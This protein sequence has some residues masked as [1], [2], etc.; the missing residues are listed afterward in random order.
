M[1]KILVAVKALDIEQRR[2]IRELLCSHFDCNAGC[3]RNGYSDQ[4]IGREANVSWPIVR[5]MRE[6][7]LGPI[8]QLPVETPHAATTDR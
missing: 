6:V 4:Q 7:V 5:M 1:G 8:K 3:Y 2:Q